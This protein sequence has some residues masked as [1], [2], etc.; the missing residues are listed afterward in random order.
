MP[1]LIPVPL[2][3]WRGNLKPGAVIS[4][5]NVGGEAVGEGLQPCRAAPDLP[6]PRP[7]AG[8]A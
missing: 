3:V 2:M 7:P 8:N 6:A 4:N 1:V 5:R